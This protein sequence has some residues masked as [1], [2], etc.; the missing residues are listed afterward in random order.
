MHNQNKFSPKVDYSMD[1][2]NPKY[3]L[4]KTPN[5]KKPRLVERC[6]SYKNNR[7]H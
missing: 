5:D 3:H 7:I 1:H 4:V 6:V 2:T